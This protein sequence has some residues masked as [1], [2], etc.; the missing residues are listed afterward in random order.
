METED[1]GLIFIGRGQRAGRNGEA[2]ICE[3]STSVEGIVYCYSSDMQTGVIIG[4]DGKR[5]VS[6]KPEWLIAAIEADADLA[7]TFEPLG[8]YARKIM[9]AR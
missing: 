1:C 9:I 4:P 6:A 7:V 8:S 3:S 5:Y 2:S